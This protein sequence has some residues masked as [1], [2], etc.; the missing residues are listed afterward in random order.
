M[1]VVNERGD[2][3]CIYACLREIERRS[4]VARNVVSTTHESGEEPHNISRAQRREIL[5]R[6]DP[7]SPIPHQVSKPLSLGWFSASCVDTYT[8]TTAK[9]DDMFCAK[10]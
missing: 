3:T 5:M 9:G 2:K 7:D 10:I 1:N 4:Y 8:K 6:A